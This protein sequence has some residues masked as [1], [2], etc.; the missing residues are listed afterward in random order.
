MKGI[1]I[2]F[3]KAFY[4]YLLKGNYRRQFLS[5]NVQYRLNKMHFYLKYQSMYVQELTSLCYL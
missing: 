1:C 4:L 3:N 5:K 2:S